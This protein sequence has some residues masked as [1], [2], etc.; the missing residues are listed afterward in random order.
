MSFDEQAT[1]LLERGLVDDEAAL[2]AALEA[3]RPRTAVERSV[4]TVS[5][6]TVPVAVMAARVER[7]GRAVVLGQMT[8][9]ELASFVPID[10]VTLPDASAYLRSTSTSARARATFGRRT[11]SATSSRP[12]ARR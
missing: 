4:L 6:E 9:D 8:P 11:R 12:G 10:S 3:A 2:R 7:R 5:R 1:A